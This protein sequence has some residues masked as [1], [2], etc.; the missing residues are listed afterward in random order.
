MARASAIKLSGDPPF[1]SF[2]ELR[3]AYQDELGLLDQFIID[4]MD[5]KVSLIQQMG[6]HIFDLGGKRIRPLL[7]FICSKMSAHPNPDQ[8]QI[9]LAAALEL[10]H[11]ATLLHDD[12][13]DESSIRRGKPTINS[14]WSNKLAILMGDY[15]FSKSFE[16]VMTADC[17]EA[18][19]ILSSATKKIT[20]GEIRQLSLLGDLT[21]TVEDYYQINAAKTASLFQ[22]ACEIGSV[23]GRLSASDRHITAEIGLIIGQIF[24]L[25]DDLLDYGFGAENI[26]KN[27]GDDFYEGKIT[28]PVMLCYQRGNPQ[29]RSF[30]ECVF[31]KS[32]RTDSEFSRA[33]ALLKTYDINNAIH[34]EIRTFQARAEQLIDTFEVGCL[35]KKQELFALIGYA[36]QRE[37]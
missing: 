12:V 6:H 33:Q 24:Q 1:L 3:S 28:L 18:L 34:K 29:D 10:L 16:S 25:K 4:S 19:Q 11:T 9:Y 35:E 14:L 13:I 15:L 2:L 5:E 21:I 22:A 27:Y 36:G 37:N 26:G 23:L 20:T 31:S 8:K 17:P 30:W 32:E 7:L